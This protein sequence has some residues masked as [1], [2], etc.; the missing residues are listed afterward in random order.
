MSAILAPAKRRT[1]AVGITATRSR[2]IFCPRLE[3]ATLITSSRAARRPAKFPLPVPRSGNNYA[4]VLSL[5]RTA[6]ILASEYGGGNTK[7][8]NF[9]LPDLTRRPACQHRDGSDSA[10][11]LVMR[12]PHLPLAGCGDHA[13]RSTL[14]RSRAKPVRP[15]MLRLT[16]VT[17]FTWPSTWP[18][19][20]GKSSAASTAS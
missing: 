7:T 15:Y 13:A 9:E 20:H 5:P 19:L 12:H 6:D 18:L 4:A 14:L 11:N 2:R 10:W 1:H 3:P 17:R 8:S 16:S